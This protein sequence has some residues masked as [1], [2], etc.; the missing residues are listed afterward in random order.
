[1]TLMIKIN[2]NAKLKSQK[3]KEKCKPNLGCLPR[4]IYFYWSHET[5]SVRPTLYCLAFQ[6][7]FAPSILST[8][9]CTPAPFKDMLSYNFPF[10]TLNRLPQ[11]LV[12]P[13]YSPEQV[14]ILVFLFV[15]PE[16]QHS[17]YPTLVVSSLV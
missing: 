3:L 6:S 15:A 8:F 7:P 10:F 14:A 11:A 2:Q 17:P 1:M 13:I 5:D 4:S 9:S 16:L 12:L